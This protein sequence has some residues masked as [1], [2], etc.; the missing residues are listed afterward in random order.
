MTERTPTLFVFA[1]H[2]NCASEIAYDNGH[3]EIGTWRY[4]M[5]VEDIVG[6]NIETIEYATCPHRWKPAAR[7]AYLHMEA[8]IFEAGMGG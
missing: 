1:C 4:V 5:G 6:Q 3:G 8:C 2:F 7:T